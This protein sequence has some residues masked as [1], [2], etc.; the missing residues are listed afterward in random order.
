M[1]HIQYIE[2]TSL[3]SYSRIGSILRPKH[4]DFDMVFLFI[5]ISPVLFIIPIP[6]NAFENEFWYITG[7]P[8]ITPI[9][10]WALSKVVLVI[11]GL[12]LL[13]RIAVPD[14]L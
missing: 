10:I 9:P 2:V 7:A 12:V 11:L 1:G 4:D 3:G 6:M 8:P 14:A 13:T 5:T